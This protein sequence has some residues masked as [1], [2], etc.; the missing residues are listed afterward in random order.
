MAGSFTATPQVIMFSFIYI[1]KAVRRRYHRFD[2]GS[3]NVTGSLHD[4]K[5][6]STRDS[7]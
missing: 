5:V 4:R 6:T 7:L 1:K 2:G 3:A